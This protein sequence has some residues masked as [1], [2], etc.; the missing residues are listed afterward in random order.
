VTSCENRQLQLLVPGVHSSILSPIALELRHLQE[1]S[2]E[3][4][5]MERCCSVENFFMSPLDSWL[6]SNAYSSCLG[7]EAADGIPLH[8]N[9]NQDEYI[10]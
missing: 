9:D 8:L 1:T 5:E 2:H 7:M 4:L 6:A 3:Q 10:S